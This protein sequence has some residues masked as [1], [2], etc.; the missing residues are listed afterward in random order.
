MT[1][2][3][4]GPGAL[5]YLPCRY[6]ASKLLFRGPRRKLE[7]PYVAFIGGTETYGRFIE[8]PFPSLVENETGLVCANFGCVNA[9]IDVFA[10]DPFV[11]G[12]AADAKVTVMQ[13]MGAHNMTNRFYSVHPRRNDRFVGPSELLKTIFRDV[14][15]SEYNFNKHLLMGLHKKSPDRFEAVYKELQSAWVARMRLMMGQ[16]RGKT[17]LLWFADHAPSDF[18]M[19]HGGLGPDPLFVTRSMMEQ[20]AP[21][22]TKVVQVVPSRRAQHDGTNGMVFNPLEAY[23]AE[24]LMGVQAHEEAA[25]AISQAIA[26]LT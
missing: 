13:V 20:V 23:S 16:M 21:Y 25:A 10:H 12:A 2:D 4:T 5:D 17:I 14:D 1:Y 15:F 6:G 7:K 9:G 26:E 19:E 8:K 18:P 3:A 22:V 11:P 24:E